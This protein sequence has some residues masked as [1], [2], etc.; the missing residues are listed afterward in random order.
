MKTIWVLQGP[1]LNLLGTREPHW[2]G[3]ESAQTLYQALET[4]A[5]TLGVRLRIEQSNHEGVLIDFIHQAHQEGAAGLICN[6]AAYAHTS[7][8]LRDALTA[9]KLPCIEVHISNT[10]KR[11]PFR[12]HSYVGEVAIGSIIGLGTQGY[13][14]ALDGLHHYLGN[15]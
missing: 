12:Q 7:I 13:L 11:E 4:R 15:L 9:T 1:N 6:A 8:A 3:N 14:L 2:Y 5:K 10:Q